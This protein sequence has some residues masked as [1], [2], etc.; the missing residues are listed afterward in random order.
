MQRRATLVRRLAIAAAVAA[1]GIV[2]AAAHGGHDHAGHEDSVDA[3]Y[4]HPGKPADVTRTITLVA[5]EMKYSETTL[6]AI[7]GETIKFV[8]INRG[9]QDHELMIADAHEQME[10]RGMM[11]S[12]GAK[13]HA[14]HHHDDGNV[15]ETKPGE[16]ASLIWT[17]SHPGSFEFACNFPGHAEH[18]MTGTITVRPRP[19]SDKVAAAADRPAHDED[20]HGASP[21][22]MHDMPGMT[23]MDHGAMPMNGAL[24]SYAMTRDAS[25]T[26]WQPDA[27]AHMGNHIQWGDWH[28]MA[29]LLV[30]AVYDWQDG[31]RGDDKAFAAGMVMAMAERDLGANDTLN[32][33][34]MLSPDTFMG[35]SGYPLLLAAGETA[36]GTTTLLDRQHPHD[37][38]MELS[39]S[40]AHR[41]DDGESI[42]LYAGLPGEPAFGPPAFMHRM[43]SLDSPQAP[44]THHWFD[45]THITFGVLTAGWVNEE[46]KIEA[47]AFR[48]REPAQRRF[49]IEAPKLDSASAR[50]SYNPSE[51][52]SLQASWADLHSPEQLNPAVDETRISAS[53][54]YTVAWEDASWWSTTL[55]WA[56]KYPS[57]GGALNALMLETAYAP[58]DDWTLFGRAEFVANRELSGTGHTDT[59][60]DISFGAIRDFTIADHVKLGLGALYTIDFVPSDLAPSYSSDNPAGAIVFLRLKASS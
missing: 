14:A 39:A 16:T 43:S 40:L 51:N 6:T 22:D 20:E 38:F 21:H 29:H 33:R 59:V 34:A 41:F 1:T 31:A 44:I 18:G 46:W 57:D 19:G 3:V 56:V 7:A 28:V 13:D 15:I 42:F 48:G 55:G 25:G 35:K 54:I 30:N 8:L 36:D 53:A 52:W 26:A 2:Q 32:L 9:T 37:L 11:L 47:S 27:S 4:G 49:D 50:V 60:G 17:F 24:G 58:N 23:G 45:S 10:H 12:M 5:T